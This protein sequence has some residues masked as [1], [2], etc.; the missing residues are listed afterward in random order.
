MSDADVTELTKT[1]N[2]LSINV[3]VLTERIDQIDKKR[4]DGVKQHI[5]KAVINVVVLS[6]ASLVWLGFI[7]TV[8][9]ASGISIILPTIQRDR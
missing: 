2:A 1:I 9:K 4:S 6:L 3:A 7:A 8:A 5:T